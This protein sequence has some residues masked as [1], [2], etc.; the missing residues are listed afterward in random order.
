ML[1]YFFYIF[2]FASVAI[3]AI[4][5]FRGTKSSKPPIEI[6]PDMDHQPKY[7]P[8]HTSIFFADGRAERPPV[9]GTVPMGYNLPGAYAATNASNSRVVYGATGFSAGPDY[10]NTGK[11]EGFWGDGLPIDIS[12]AVMARGRERYEIN[13]AICH[14]MSGD[15]NGIVKEYGLATVRSLQEERIRNMPDGELFHVITEGRNTM[16]AYGPQITVED[17]WAIVAY[18]RALHRSQNATLDNVPAEAR[19]ALEK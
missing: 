1:R 12:S 15:G 18:L 2:F 13:C 4:A 10:S 5:G 17:R 19:A 6:F 3:V 14:G 9:P 8:Q 16:G 7:Q 11:I